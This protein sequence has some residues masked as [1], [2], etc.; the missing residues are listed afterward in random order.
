M[1]KFRV[2]RRYVRGNRAGQ[3][4]VKKIE[5]PSPQSIFSYMWDV[6]DNFEKHKL[7]FIIERYLVM[8][9]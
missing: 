3:A 1:S 9:S 7:D 4:E 5:L 8:E 2:T 6:V